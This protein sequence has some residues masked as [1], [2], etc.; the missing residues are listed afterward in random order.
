MEQKT[1]VDQVGEQLKQAVVSAALNG[2]G[3]STEAFQKPVKSEETP[4]ASARGGAFVKGGT[5]GPGRPKG[6]VPKV[7]KTIR[8]AVMTAFNEVGGPEYLVRLANGT[9]SDRAAFTS[10]LNKVLPTQINANVDGGIRLELSWLGGRNIGTTQ[11]QLTEQAPQV[12]DIEQD[13]AGKYRI[14]DQQPQAGQADRRQE[15]QEGAEA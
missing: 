5:P 3:E 11:A 1:Q 7:T 10:L 12:I 8:D 6:S 9:Q 2:E 13:S 14:K 15:G 4:I